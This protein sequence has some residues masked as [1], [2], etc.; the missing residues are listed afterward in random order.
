MAVMTKKE[1]V[2]GLPNPGRALQWMQFFYQLHEV[3]A[4][5]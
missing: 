4:K 2:T 5:K 3:T 1:P